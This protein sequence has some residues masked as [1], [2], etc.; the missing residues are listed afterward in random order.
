MVDIDRSPE[1]RRR[2]KVVDLFGSECEPTAVR[3][4]RQTSKEVRILA[5]I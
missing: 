3:P 5:F 1:Y 4:E 2:L